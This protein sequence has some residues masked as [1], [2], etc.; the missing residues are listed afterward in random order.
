MVTIQQVL[1]IHANWC[2]TERHPRDVCNCGA[3]VEIILHPFLKKYL[4]LKSTGLDTFT[5]AKITEL[6]M[7]ARSS[8]LHHAGIY[9][10]QQLRSIDKMQE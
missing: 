6:T 9:I 8:A 10:D 1:K 3:K 4:Y 5:A 7:Q 2:L